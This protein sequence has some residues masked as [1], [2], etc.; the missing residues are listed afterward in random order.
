MATALEHLAA[1]CWASTCPAPRGRRACTPP[2]RCAFSLGAAGAAGG[3][4]GRI[5]SVKVR[6]CAAGSSLSRSSA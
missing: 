6:S 3:G 4:L 1:C 2:P 5:W